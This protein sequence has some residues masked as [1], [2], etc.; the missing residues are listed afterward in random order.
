MDNTY[1]FDKHE[2]I[3]NH[4]FHKMNSDINS[5]IFRG[6]NYIESLLISWEKTVFPNGE[7]SVFSTCG[8]TGKKFNNNNYWHCELC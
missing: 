1:F 3:F 6:N 4:D 5:D 2:Q 8:K 7:N